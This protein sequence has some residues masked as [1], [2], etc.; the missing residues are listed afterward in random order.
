MILISCGH[1]YKFMF[2]ISLENS[3]IY[4]VFGIVFM[5]D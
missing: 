5:K 3:I 4:Y 1:E 2:Y